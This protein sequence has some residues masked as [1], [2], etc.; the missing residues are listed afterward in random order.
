MTLTEIKHSITTSETKNQ[1]QFCENIIFYFTL[2][3]RDIWSTETIIDKEKIEAIKWLNE[4]LHRTINLKFQLEN[5]KIENNISS[6]F[7]NVIF[8]S[9][10]NETTKMQ[11]EGVILSAFKKLNNCL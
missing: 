7:E 6:L 3:V 10:Q 5:K 11:L 9:N 2:A 1:I 8:Y 4:F